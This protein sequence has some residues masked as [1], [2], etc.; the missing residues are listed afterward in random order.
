MPSLTKS[1]KYLLA[2]NIAG[3]LIFT[4]LFLARENYEFI[5]YIAVIVFFLLVILFSHER[6]NYP[7]GLLW[8]L[9]IWSYLHMAGGGLYLQGTKF[10]EL[11]LF[12]IVG[13]PYNIFKYDQFVHAVG[14]WVATI[15]AYHLIKPMMKEESIKKVSFALVIVM[16]GLGFGALNEIVEFVATV[17]IPETGVGGY[18]N[19]ALDL[20]FDLVGAI[21]AM[22]YLRIKNNPKIGA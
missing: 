11:M 2:V 5:I 8:G 14:F 18:T 1:L 22:V 4:Y 19:T 12:P 7:T 10:Y 20:V 17:I 13:E 6:V 3:I 9:T 16:A 15:L 21:G